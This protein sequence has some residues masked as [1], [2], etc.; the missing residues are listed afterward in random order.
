MSHRVTIEVPQADTAAL[1]ERLQS[2]PPEVGQ[3]ATSR[4]GGLALDESVLQ[5]VLTSIT[6]ISTLVGVVT[7]AWLSARRPSSPATPDSKDAPKGEGDAAR[8]VLILE[9]ADRDV[10]VEVTASGAVLPPGL[11]ESADHVLRL[12]FANG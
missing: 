9:L 7:T 2:L 10:Q 12:R 1:R 4:P 5:I 6:S 11:P 8:P 3:L